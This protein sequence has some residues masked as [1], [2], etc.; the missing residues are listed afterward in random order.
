MR[1]RIIPILIVIVVAA[2]IGYYWW[3]SYGGGSAAANSALGGSG[4]IEAQQIAIT[5]QVSLD[6]VN[7]PNTREARESARLDLRFEDMADETLFNGILWR[8][9]KG[10]APYPG[11]RRISVLELARA[12]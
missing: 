7:R 8:M 10:D 2:A 9:M 11:T 5:P 3:T 6:E 1:K 4:T 12:R